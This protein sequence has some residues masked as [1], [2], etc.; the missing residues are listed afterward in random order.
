MSWVKGE[1]TLTNDK[2][3]IQQTREVEQASLSWVRLCEEPRIYGNE[4]IPAP[5]PSLKKS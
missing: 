5:L 4:M 2:K 3:E 1:I